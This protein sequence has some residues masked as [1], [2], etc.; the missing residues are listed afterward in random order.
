METRPE[1]RRRSASVNFGAAAVLVATLSGCSASAQ[2][3]DYD[4]AAVCA[5]QQT[6][7]RVNDDDDCDDSG[8]YGWY[9]I[10]VGSRAPAVGESVS[11]GSFTAPSSDQAVC[12]GGA[13]NEG[14]VVER[15]GFGSCSE[16]VGG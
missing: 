3:E 6:Q 11:N 4:Y 15:G 2:E 9:Y 16:S 7:L 14:G 10:P 1:T 13:P 8:A 5:D 12:L